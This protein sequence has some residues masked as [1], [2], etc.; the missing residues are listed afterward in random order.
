MIG[1]AYQTSN[2][3]TGSPSH[4]TTTTFD[5]LGRPTSIKLPDNSPTSY[6]YSLN[7]TTVTDPAG[8]QRKSVTDA[9]GRST[10]VYEPDP[11]NGNSLTLQ[12]S[13]TYNVLDELTQVKQGSQTRTY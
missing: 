6:A 9:A 3:Y 10:T 2:P 8:K 1:R 4:W 13:S 7:T 5:A 11:A 12:T